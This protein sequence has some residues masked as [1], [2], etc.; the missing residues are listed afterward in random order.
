MI[1]TLSTVKTHFRSLFDSAHRWWTACFFLASIILVTASL[2]VGITDNLPGIAMLLAGMIFLFL[3]F[4]HAWRRPEFYVMLAGG[5]IGFAFL[6]YL[7]IVLLSA[8]HKTKYVNEGLVMGF[9][10]L[11]CLPGIV[12]GVIGALICAV[13]K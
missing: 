8:F 3:S 1:P 12:A 11:I 6:M 10:G 5:C 13:K 2:I 9:A 7:A 4:L